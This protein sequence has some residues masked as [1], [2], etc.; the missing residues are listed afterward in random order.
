MKVSELQEII[1]AQTGIKTSVRKYT[2]SMKNH[3]SFRPQFQGGRYP[4]F[5]YEWANEFKKQ[6]QTLPGFGNYFTNGDMLDILAINFTEYD[7]I[8]YKKERKPKTIDQLNVKQ[9]G[10]KTAN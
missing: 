8:I 1:L 6:F 4:K 3:Y 9:W 10:A 7:P 2:G 5:P